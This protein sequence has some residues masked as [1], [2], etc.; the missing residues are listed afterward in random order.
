VANLCIAHL[1][2]LHHTLNQQ[3]LNEVGRVRR[4]AAPVDGGATL[5]LD[6][7]VRC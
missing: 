4:G 5:D 2:H 6:G 1:G 3:Q 7:M